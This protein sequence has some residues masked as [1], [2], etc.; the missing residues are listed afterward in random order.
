MKP[1][2][3][4]ITTDGRGCSA[5]AAAIPVPRSVPPPPTSASWLVLAARWTACTV[6]ST[7]STRTWRLRSPVRLSTASISTSARASSSSLIEF[8]VSQTIAISGSGRCIAGRS[9]SGVRSA[10]RAGRR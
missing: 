10:R 3:S 5:A 9:K 2:V 1:S 8:E 7:D 6:V 4:P